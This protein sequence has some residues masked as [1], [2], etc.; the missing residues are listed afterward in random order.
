MR[1]ALVPIDTGQAEADA[2]KLEVA[3]RALE[4]AVEAG[5]LRLLRDA[6]GEHAVT[7][8]PDSS[9]LKQA[10]HTSLTREQCWEKGSSE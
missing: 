3:Q 4:A 5:E 9:I 8:G 2:A 1:F 10:R 6:I 7:V